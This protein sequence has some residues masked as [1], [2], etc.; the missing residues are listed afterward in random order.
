METKNLPIATSPAS[1]S[2]SCHGGGQGSGNWFARRRGLILAG[3]AATGIAIGLGQH[4]L[5]ASELTPLLFLLPC[6]A[7]MFMCMKGMNHGQQAG[8]APASV[9]TDTPVREK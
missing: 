5:T 3:A 8:P 6:L 7:M 2:S 4:W 1:R 9:S